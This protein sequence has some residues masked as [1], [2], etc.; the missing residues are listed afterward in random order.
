MK[1]LQATALR[2]DLYGEL[3]RVRRTRA[4][5]EIQRHGR[6]I[7]VLAPCVDAPAGRRKPTIDLDAI[8]SFC[9][10]HRVRKFF[11]FGSILRDDFDENSDVD[12]M[13]D[14]D[15]RRLG[16]HEMCG[17]LDELEVMFGRRVDML[18]KQS[19]DSPEMNPHRRESIAS[20]AR[21]LFET[22]T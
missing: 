10:Q 11:L 17:M 15:G 14:I 13:I 4:P 6:P 5:V 22:A 3:K 12:V 21:L 1:T 2:K 20:S 8:S 9:K 16:F 19:I 7:A 18:T